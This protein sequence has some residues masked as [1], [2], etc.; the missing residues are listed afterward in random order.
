VLLDVDDA[1]RFLIER[2][3]IDNTWILDGSLIVRRLERRNRNLKVVGR[4]G[5]GF[6][7]KQPGYSMA[8]SRDTLR[9][10]AG[11]HRLCREEPAMAPVARAIP[12]LVAAEDRESIL[13]FEAIPDAITLRQYFE[14]GG[15]RRRTGEAAAALGHVLGDFH[16]ALPTEGRGDDPRLGWLPRGLP[17]ALSIHRPRPSLLATLGPAGRELLGVL[18]RDEAFWGHIDDLRRHWRADAVIHGDIRFD[19]VLVRPFLD[20]LEA[21]P[22][23]PWIVD[24]EMVA[25]GDPAWDLAG[26][27]QDLLVLWVSSMPMSEGANVEQMTAEAR[28]PLDVLRVAA[29]ALWDGYRR[30]AALD[31][32]RAED[33]LY[34]AVLYS[35]ARLVQSAFEYAGGAER[36]DGPAVLLL[37]IAANLLDDPHLGRV[38][39]YGIPPSRI[40]S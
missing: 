10:E 37:Q 26:A 21:V 1:I 24:W 14:P 16:R 4:G 32:V 30:G 20:D 13:V 5:L 3:L 22:E 6:V 34:R 7:I 35:A 38:H 17:W 11:F 15:S 12:R 9:C 18:Q 36:L 8:E 23:G 2:G 27:L 19:N 40:A 29:I 33:L 25:V 28:I 39:L 31:L